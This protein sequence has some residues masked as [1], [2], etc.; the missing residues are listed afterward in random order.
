MFTGIIEAMG[1]VVSLK[2]GGH[3][4]RLA[5]RLPASWRTLKLGS[6]V[7]VNGACLT[8]VSKKGGTVSFDLVPET[9]QRTTLGRLLPGERVNLERPMHARA[10][11][12]GHFV[13][14]HI[15]G[16]GRVQAVSERG[17]SKVLTVSFPTALKRFI[18]EKGSVAVDGVSLT[19]GRVRRSSFVI[20]IIPETLKRTTFGRLEKGSRTNLETDVLMKGR[21][22]RRAIN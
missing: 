11:V 21:P 13:L 17:R 15:E 7:C 19:L 12:H 14:G 3:A 9:L 10:R 16:V 4:A 1:K 6:S 18:K 20:H 8:V 2:K 5:L 22:R